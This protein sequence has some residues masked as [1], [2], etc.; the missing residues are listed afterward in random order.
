MHAYYFKSS[1]G[2]FRIFLFKGSFWLEIEVCIVLTRPL[3]KQPWMFTCT[4]LAI[5]VG[6]S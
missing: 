4:P 6:T 1:V 5:M 2:F 3:K